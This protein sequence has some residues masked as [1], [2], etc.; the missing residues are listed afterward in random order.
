MQLKLEKKMFVL[1]CAGKVMTYK[2]IKMLKYEI[3][4][5][6]NIILKYFLG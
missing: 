2:K 6:K 1:V 4:L 5:K 3:V